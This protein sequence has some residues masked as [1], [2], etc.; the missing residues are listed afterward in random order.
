MS[1]PD[2]PTPFLPLV[3]G[4]S[5]FAFILERLSR[6]T[7]FGPVGVG[8]DPQ[9]RSGVNRPLGEANLTGAVLLEPAPR[10]TA[11]AIAAAAAF[12]AAADP[13]ATLLILPADQVI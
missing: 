4:R 1:R 7:G 11:P 9:R 13:F 10:G 3:E 8:G 6:S 12:V 5:T 2:E